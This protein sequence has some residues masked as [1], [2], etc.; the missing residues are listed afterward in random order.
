MVEPSIS[1]AASSLS[2]PLV[3]NFRSGGDSYIYDE[4]NHPVSSVVFFDPAIWLRE[5]SGE[6]AAYHHHRLEHRGPN[7]RRR[8][9]AI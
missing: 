7:C 9:E 3:V 4:A 8:G 2:V 1:A 6:R 5:A